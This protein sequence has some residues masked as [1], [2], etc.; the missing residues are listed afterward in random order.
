MFEQQ[1]PVGRKCCVDLSRG[2]EVALECEC[3]MLL[4]RKVCAISDPQCQCLGSQNLTDAQ[5][6][7][8]FEKVGRAIKAVG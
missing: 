3:E 8:I 5:I 1:Q 2:I 4:T 7:E 6:G